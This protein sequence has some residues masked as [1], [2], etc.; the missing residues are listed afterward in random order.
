MKVIFPQPI[1]GDLLN[2]VHLSNVFRMLD[3]P[4]PHVGG[5]VMTE[6]KTAS[7]INAD[8]G[9]AVEVTCNI[10]HDGRPATSSN[11]FE[12]IQE[13]GYVAEYPMDASI[14]VLQVSYRSITVS[15]DLTF[16]ARSNGSSRLATWTLSRMTDGNP[17]VA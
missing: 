12:I 4:S 6:A 11:T 8:A 15:G 10:I 14:D 13:P 1:D 2:L 5:V 17:V 7:I 16:V 9:K 3:M